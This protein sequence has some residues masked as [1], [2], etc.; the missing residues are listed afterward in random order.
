MSE[1]RLQSEVRLAAVQLGWTLWR[2]N[3]GAGKIQVPNGESRFI[4]WGLANDSSQ[5]NEVFKSSDLIGY[6]NTARFAA[7]ECKDPNW[8]YKGT[9][10]EVAQLAFILHVRRGGGRAGFVTDPSQLVL[11]CCFG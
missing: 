3:N 8:V 7:A 4:R 6:D 2:N 10:R 11:Q 1:S 5:L 9:P